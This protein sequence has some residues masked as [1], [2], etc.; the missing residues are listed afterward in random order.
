VR[1]SRPDLSWVLPLFGTAD[2]VDELV[3]RIARASDALGVAEEIILVDDACPHGSG[4]TADAVAK[5]N[6]S[7]RVLHLVSNIGQDSALREGLRLARGAWA[8]IL[9]ADLQDPP[10]AVAQLW[11]KRTSNLG[12]IF[13]AREGR[14]TSTGRHFSSR[15]YRSVMRHL[16]GLPAGACLFVLVDR[17]VVDT[18][19][20]TRRT[21][22]SLLA[23]IAACRRPM[24]SVR[25]Q[26]S[27][28]LSGESAYPSWMRLRKAAG[29]I[30]QAIL[31]RRLGLQL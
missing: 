3:T 18:I 28:R 31:A 14:Y 22:I 15:V 2:F 25:V 1:V 16:G 21:P 20:A 26:R 5:S 24:L 17:A 19:G 13:A 6:P 11:S 4:R 23:S 12:A 30:W 7:V 8:V 27:P 10:E 29:S 9:D